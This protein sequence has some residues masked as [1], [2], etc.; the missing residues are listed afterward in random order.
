M[1]K[2]T[3]SK[4]INIL[5]EL[6]SE[7]IEPI[8]LLAIDFA[9]RGVT[10]L[11]T[12]KTEF[13]S[14]IPAGDIIWNLYIIKS[15][16]KTFESTYF[17][18]INLG[19]HSLNEQYEL[20]ELQNQTLNYS[21]HNIPEENHPKPLKVLFNKYFYEIIWS[22]P[23]IWIEIGHNNFSRTEFQRNF[24]DENKL[25][26]CPFCDID[27]I[28]NK[29]NSFV[30]HFLPKDSFPFLSCNGRNLI[31]TCNACNMAETGKGSEVRLPITTP[32]DQEIGELVKFVLLNEKFS[33]DKNSKLPVENYIDLLKLRKKYED[34]SIY[35]RAIQYFKLQYS[36]FKTKPEEEMLSYLRENGRVQGLY[37]LSRD[38]LDFKKELKIYFKTE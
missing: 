12:I 36:H 16:N 5:K 2:I 23:E 25:Y 10:D 32:Y 8:F 11:T 24:K 15:E 9:K 19:E 30:E 34:S 6:T 26:V 22:T 33:I 18:V 7:I 27:T 38:I 31:S 21:N 29:A 17:E 20:Y 14:K 1:W 37:F 3:N 4:N 28:S 13:L 35:D